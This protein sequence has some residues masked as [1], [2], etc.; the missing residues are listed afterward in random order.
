MDKKLRIVFMGTPEFA[1]PSL[2][3]L[4]KNGWNVVA[5]VTAPDRPQGRGQ[6]LIP[7]PVKV[8]ALGCNIPVLQPTNLKSEN[9]I[10][11]LRNLKA[12]LQ[13]VVAFRMLPE[14]VWNMP[15]RGT[16]NLHASLLPN[17]RGAAPINWAI[18]KG[19]KETGLTTFFLK[20]EIDTGSII[21]QEKE[22]I[23]A[24]DNIGTL[25]ER[26][27][28]KGAQ[29]VL[30]TTEAI[31]NNNVVTLPQNEALAIHHAPKIFKETCE[32]DW[33][34]PVTDIHNLIRGLSPY[35]GAWTILD[36]KTCKIYKSEISDKNPE[37][38]L[39]GE[40]RSDGKKELLFQT[41]NGTLKILELQM[42]GKKKL[43][44]EEF[45]RGY[46]LL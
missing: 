43:V 25:Y 34:K 4:V 5:V 37:G 13:I 14:V 19:E 32:I 26:L 33:K 31:E 20:H 38:L 27:M 44:I 28:N 24:E 10:E 35:P 42:E 7:S 41:G 2:E 15:P 8:A 30:K 39:P 12:D 29:L 40:Y 22:P 23:N 16:F 46:K 3:I 9:F 6:K 1:V 17:Y 45:L 21:F 18:I 11:E 36:G